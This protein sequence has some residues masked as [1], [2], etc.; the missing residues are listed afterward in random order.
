VCFEL[1]FSKKSS[2]QA[3]IRISKKQE[4]NQSQ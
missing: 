4:L 3:T 1:L 2:K